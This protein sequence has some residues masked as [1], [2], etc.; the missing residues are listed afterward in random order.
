MKLISHSFEGRDPFKK[1]IS[2]KKFLIKFNDLI[3][4]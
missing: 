4:N 1:D 2:H 3:A